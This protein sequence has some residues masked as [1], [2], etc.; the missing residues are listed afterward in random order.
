MKALLINPE[1]RSIEAVDIGNHAELASLIGYDTIES[2]AVGTAGDRLYFDEECFLRGT[3]GR[4][5]IDTLIPVSGM[6]VIVGSAGDGAT[7]RDVTA[8]IEDVRSRIK[9]L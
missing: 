3:T 7:L 4:F 6:G 8:D 1:T 5:Q 2:D 9:Y